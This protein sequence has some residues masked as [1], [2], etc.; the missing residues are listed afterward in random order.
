MYD[1]ELKRGV[2]K[3]Y[4]PEPNPQK[5]ELARDATLLD[6]F[7][8]AKELYFSEVETDINSLCLADSGGVLIPVKNRILVTVFILPE[9]SLAA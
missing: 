6:D 7:K 8:K 2:R 1:N 5:V 4:L 9:E 3:R